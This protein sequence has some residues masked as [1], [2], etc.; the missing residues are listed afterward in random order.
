MPG[1]TLLKDVHI[2]IPS[3][4]VS[5]GVASIIQGS[6]EYYHY[7]QDGFDDSVY[8]FSFFHGFKTL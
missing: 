5:E 7:L 1:S 8:H 4:G 6:Y 3:S 2:G